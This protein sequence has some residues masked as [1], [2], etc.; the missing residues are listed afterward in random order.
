MNV[1]RERVLFISILILVFWV[2][3][4]GF[5]GNNALNNMNRTQNKIEVNQVIKSST[6]EDID[7]EVPESG[8]VWDIGDTH[9]IQWDCDSYGTN[10]VNIRLYR[11][12]TLVQRIRSGQSSSD[13]ENTITWKVP[14]VV[15]DDNY[16]IGIQDNDTKTIYYSDYFTIRIK[17]EIWV[18]PYIASN[19]IAGESMKIEW[20]TAGS[21]KNVDILLVN[22]YGQT[23]TIV[24]ETTNDGEYLW[25]IPWYHFPGT[26]Q[27]RIRDSSE[28]D[29]Y[30]DGSTFSI[31]FS[32]AYIIIIISM[33]GVFIAIISFGIY[34]LIRNQGRIKLELIQEPIKVEK[35]PNIFAMKI[36]PVVK[37]RP[38]FAPGSI[39]FSFVLVPITKL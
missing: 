31:Q 36:F 12:S 20:N 18:K 17:K 30:D 5:D 3:F 28:T 27:V 33:I 32:T 10:Y 13:G 24:S 38:I 19:Y 37:N 29:I 21:I 11:G 26:Y 1:Q 4:T 35:S 6:I 22:Q 7:V 39:Q 34:I 14:N 2:N 15:E 23:E 16:R 9:T 8:D 25:E